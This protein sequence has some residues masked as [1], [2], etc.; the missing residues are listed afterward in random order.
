M[1]IKHLYFFAGNGEKFSPDMSELL[2][3]KSVSMTHF[4]NGVSSF[5]V[6]GTSIAALLILHLSI[7]LTK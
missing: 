7:L 3:V 1:C 2:L 6:Q 5:T 4:T